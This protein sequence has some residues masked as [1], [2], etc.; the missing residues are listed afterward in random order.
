MC[1]ISL[2]SGIGFINV[3]VSSLF[4]FLTLNLHYRVAYRLPSK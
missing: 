4:S 2:I 1:N 3:N